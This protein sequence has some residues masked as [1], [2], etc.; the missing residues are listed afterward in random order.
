M[1]LHWSWSDNCGEI[2]VR[3]SFP[4]E[5]PQEHTVRL[6]DGNALLIMI[7]EFK[8]EDTGENLYAL[9]NFFADKQHM[10]NCLGLNKKNGYADN[11]FQTDHQTITKIRLDKSKCRGWKDIVTAF[12]QAFDDI[13]IELYTTPTR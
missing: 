4:G 11:M 5:E 6:Y 3:S 2:T 1:A 10:K 7:N 9:Y 8:D 12:A 13:V